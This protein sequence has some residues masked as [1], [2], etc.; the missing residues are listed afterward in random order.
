MKWNEDM[1]EISDD[2]LVNKAKSGDIDAY[3]ELA[4]RYQKRIYHMILGLTKNPLDAD[5][6][7]QE[8][9]LNGFVSLKRFK[10][11]SGFYTWIY[12][13][14]LNLTLN[15]LKKKGRE[16]NKKEMEKKILE[17]KNDPSAVVPEDQSLKKELRKKLQ[18][19]IDSLPVLY[20]TSF[21]LV[22]FQGMSHYQAAKVMRCSENTI[23]WRLHKARKMLQ[24]KLRPYLERGEL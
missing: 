16:K 2:L 24:T 21:V 20:K 4:R 15:F 7:A 14:A 18:E 11:K 5:D 22:E 1:E 13:I 9:F 8:T 12:R 23:S 3:T 10:Q 17:N 19:S 6:L